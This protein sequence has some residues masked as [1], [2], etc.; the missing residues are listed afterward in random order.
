MRESGP[1]EK[2]VSSV[3]TLS[4]EGAAEEHAIE[5]DAGFTPELGH[6]HCFQHQFLA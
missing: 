3:S 5:C 4:R 2:L 1:A 6:T